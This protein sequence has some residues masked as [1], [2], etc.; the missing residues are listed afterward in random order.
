[1]AEA[2]YAQFPKPTDDWYT[3][4]N[5]FEVKR[6][7]DNL[8]K[9]PEIHKRILADFNTHIFI[10]H[11]EKVF[12][13]DGLIP[14]PSFRGG[15]LH[16]IMPGGKLDVHIDFNRH[17][18]LKLHRRINAILYLN[19]HWQKEWGGHLELWDSEMKKCVKKVAPLFNRMVIFETTDFS[20]H[21]HP[22]PLNF[23]PGESRKSMAWYFFLLIDQSTKSQKLTQLCLKKD[24]KTKLQKKLKSLEINEERVEYARL[25][26]EL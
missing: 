17:P 14:D 2:L 8:L 24:L 13:I 1:V 22:E 26:F 11:I 25:P 19:K 6:A 20:Y 16:Q 7:Q 5:V 21:G 10:D 9:I 12:G 23:P 4:D 3:Y 18:K 15:G